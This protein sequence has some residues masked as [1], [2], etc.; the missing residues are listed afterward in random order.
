MAWHI[1]EYIGRYDS[2]GLISYQ[3]PL[4]PS[5]TRGLLS[6]VS[7]IEC[8]THRIS[9]GTGFLTRINTVA[10]LAYADQSCGTRA[11]NSVSFAWRL[12]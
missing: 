4:P 6:S 10:R 12:R 3:P 7:P 5:Q 11:T 1:F 8:E 9:I 2:A